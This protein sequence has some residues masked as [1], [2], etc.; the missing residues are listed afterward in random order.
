M[1]SP[2]SD[3]QPET[4]GDV[5]SRSAFSTTA[6]KNLI[7]KPSSPSLYELRMEMADATGR[8]H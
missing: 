5:L 2:I 1:L 8:C 3:G 4:A 7:R 6:R